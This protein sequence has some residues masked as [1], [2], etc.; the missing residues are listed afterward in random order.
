VRMDRHDLTV[1]A[2]VN[3]RR[4]MVDRWRSRCLSP[5]TSPLRA[6]TGAHGVAAGLVRPAVHDCPETSRLSRRFRYVI[7]WPRLPSR[8]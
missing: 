3:H 6:E 2:G 1:L 7:T 4:R 5:L 8:P